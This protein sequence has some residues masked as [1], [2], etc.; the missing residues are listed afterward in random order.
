MENIE[1]KTAKPTELSMGEQSVSRTQ[2]SALSS[3]S[4]LSSEC[5]ELTALPLITQ[6]VFRL[7]RALGT[8]SSPI[9]N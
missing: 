5:C 9:E 3:N 6:W 4:V 7:D 8:D 2:Y 1:L